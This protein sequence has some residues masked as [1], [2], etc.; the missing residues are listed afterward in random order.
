MG[1]FNL[2]GNKKNEAQSEE[3]QAKALE[4][5]KQ[6]AKEEA[7]KAHEELDWPVIMR[8]NPVNTKD[9]NGD[10]MEETVSPERKEEV[11]ALIYE[12][13]LD[14]VTLGEL[15][16]QEL[17]FLLT[18]MEMFNKKAPL[19]GFEK[20]HRNGCLHLTSFQNVLRSQTFIMH[21]LLSCC[22]ISCH[23]HAYGPV[24]VHGQSHQVH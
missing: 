22:L 17:L 21:T 11:G 10:V 7:K 16:G 8:L 6:K 4:L 9:A 12:D 14:S 23:M 13:E 5:Q 2:F 18:A 24:V 20:N 1:I 15:T 3:E 19:E